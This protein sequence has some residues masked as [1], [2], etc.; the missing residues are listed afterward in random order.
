[1]LWECKFPPYDSISAVHGPKDFEIHRLKGILY[2][3]AGSAKIIQAVR[4][5]FEI[6]DVQGSTVDPSD[7]Q[8]FQCKVALI[9]RGLGH[10]AGPWQRSFD[11]F[12]D[13]GS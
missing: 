7:S 2:M 5:V 1:M 12:L 11:Y 3:E 4:E 10:D 8:A 6:R 13:S 9:G